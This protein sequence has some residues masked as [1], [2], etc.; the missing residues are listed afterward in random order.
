MSTKRKQT[1]RRVNQRNPKGTGG[2]YE[3]NGKWVAFVPVGRTKSG[4]SARKTKTC[5]TREEAMIEWGKLIDQLNKNQLSAGPNITFRK[6]A[7]HQPLCRLLEPSEIA[8]AIA[9][10]AS[11]NSSAITGANL[12]ID[13][14]MTV[15]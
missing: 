8:S 7:V 6:F 15:S 11:P 4:N 5:D 13:G 3:K 10:V 12:A 1:P 2:I 14:G 9:W